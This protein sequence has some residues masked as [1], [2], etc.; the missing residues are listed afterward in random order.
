MPHE[1]VQF[2]D[3]DR[4]APTSITVHW[5]KPEAGGNLQ[6]RFARHAFGTEGEE[7]YEPEIDQY[8]DQLSRDDCNRLIRAL[9][10]ARDQV[11]GADA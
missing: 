2:A 1:I 11:Y 10:R 6:L 4:P 7:R 8:S 9:R 3:T 5:S